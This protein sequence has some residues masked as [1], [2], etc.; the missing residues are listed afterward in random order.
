MSRLH[1]HRGFI[2]LLNLR[3][4]RRSFR[5]RNPSRSLAI[6]LR[7][8]GFKMSNIVLG[9]GRIIFIK[10]ALNIL[11]LDVRILKLS[12]F[13]SFIVDRKKEYLNASV[14]QEYVLIFL[15]FQVLYKWDSEGLTQL[16]QTEFHYF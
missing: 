4:N 1:V 12:L 6:N 8:S 2:Q 5:G 11:K 13:H 9:I 14:L 3:L 15:V 7:P 16:N 10:L